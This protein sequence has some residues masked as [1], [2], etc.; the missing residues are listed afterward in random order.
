MSKKIRNEVKDARTKIQTA[1][2][3]VD[4][5]SSVIQGFNDLTEAKA[6]VINGTMIYLYTELW[7]SNPATPPAWMQNAYIYLR[8]KHDLPEGKT[9]YFRDIET[10]LLIGKYEGGKAILV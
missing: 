7:G 1:G 6:V 9:I 10:D 2:K 8:M 3:K 5:M 4:H